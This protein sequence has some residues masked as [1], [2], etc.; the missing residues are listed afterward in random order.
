MFL[1]RVLGEGL[2]IPFVAAIIEKEER[3]RKY[4]LIQK[5]HKWQDQKYCGAWEIPGGKFRAFED[6]FDTLRREVREE[7]GLEITEISG[8]KEK[9]QYTNRS[10]ESTIIKPYC[11]TQMKEGPFVGLVF[12]VKAKGKLVDRTKETREIQWIDKEDLK[13]MIT[14]QPETFYTA[15]IGPLREYLKIR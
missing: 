1:P 7:C 10:D 11:V 2:Y 13:Q 3:G 6:V 12:L 14:R 4:V 15:F 9:V 8:E 5:R